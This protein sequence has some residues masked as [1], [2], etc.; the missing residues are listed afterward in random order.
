MKITLSKIALLLLGIFALVACDNT[1][2]PVVNPD[3]DP[4][5]N[6][7]LPSDA[8][9]IEVEEVHA[10]SA[11][12][13]VTP[14]DKQMYYVMY[15]DVV[16]YFQDGGIET[17]EQLWEDDF[18]AFERG[19]VESNMSLKDYMLKANIAFQGTTR[20]QWNSVLPGQKSLLYIYGIEFSEDG[21]SYEPVT[22]IAWTIIE[23]EYA[24]LQD[25]EFD[26]GIDVNGAEVALSVQPKEW[27][28]YYL[29]KF[30][31][32]NSELYVGEGVEFDEAYMSNIADEWIAVLNSNLRGGHTVEQV[33]NEICFKGATTI[34]T[35]LSTYTLYSA[36]VYPVAEYDGYVQVVAEPSY[37]NF[38]TEEVG[39][40]Q[41]TIDIEITN[42]YVRV[43]DL[44]VT[45]SKADESYILLITP[46]EYLPA[47][48]DNN[49]LLDLAL[50]EF[51]YYTQ[52][53]KGEITS[54][55][56]T[57]YSEKEY[58]VVAFGYSGGVVTTGVYSEV[59]KTQKEGKCELEV[60][61]VVVGGPYR[62]TDLYNYDPETF[63]YYTKPYYYD[64]VQFI[65]TLEVKTSAPTRDIF[66][67]FVSKDDY[68]W[69]GY[70]TTF[71]D[72]LIDTC[73][74]LA[75][76]EGFWD[77]GSYY[78]CAAA[79][80]Y[81]GDVTDMWM[82]DL[83]TWTMDDFRPIDEFIEK[84]E[85]RDAMVVMGLNADGGIVPLNKLR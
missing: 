29:V 55:M 80:D 78:A 44:R 36:L 6:T 81:K 45:P 25:V 47:G 51:S 67:Y 46:T 15:L 52:T 76:A 21:A 30:V 14:V 43:A 58:I 19:A 13:E 1:E 8:F 69:G 71:Y 84:W 54:H 33:L 66:S 82:S 53:F 62:P 64:S 40:S 5:N 7:Q 70:D 60:T 24:P 18:S 2:G 28:G 56:N 73:D 22:E 79:F 31:D 65:V 68:E 72:L 12:T 75:L 41:M 50:G 20:V 74:P 26:L 39:Q 27:E 48:Y 34:N 42:C 83:I 4:S 3:D 9:A 38:S 23:P 59:F 77:Y 16:S 10:T 17:A 63:K 61:D 35:E 49:T 32:A 85:A 37:I 11:I 57:L